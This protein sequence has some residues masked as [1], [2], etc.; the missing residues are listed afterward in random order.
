[1]G[2]VKE[3]PHVLT[4]DGGNEMGCEMEFMRTLDKQ[5]K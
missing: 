5:L 1:M 3:S 2:R 4:I